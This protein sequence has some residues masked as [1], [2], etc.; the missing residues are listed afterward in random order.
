VN[1][2]TAPFPGESR[3]R[4]VS[5]WIPLPPGLTKFLKRFLYRTTWP[6]PYRVHLTSNIILTDRP[7]PVNPAPPGFPKFPT[8]FLNRTTGPIPYR[9]HLTSKIFFYR[10]AVTVESRYRPV[11]R[12]IPLPPCFPKF[13]IRFL[14]R[15]TGP[16]PYRVH[17]TS[18]IIF[19]RSAV[20]GESRYPWHY[21]KLPATHELQYNSSTESINW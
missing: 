9:V 14:N 20:N 12:W 15:T 1:P 3:Y 19:Y 8:R 4:P 21:R 5:R 17:L 10:P 7:L 2:V 16:I 18:K 13:P 11:F 6:I